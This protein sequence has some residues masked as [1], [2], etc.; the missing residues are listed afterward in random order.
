VD[1][2]L[3]SRLLALGSLPA[4]ALA[5]IAGGVG[6]PI[7]EEIVLLAAGALSH[8]GVTDPWITLPTCALAILV[9]DSVLYAL[10]RRLGPRL[11]ERGPFRH[12]ATPRRLERID[13]LFER[14]GDLLIFAARHMSL[15]RTLVF[16]VAATRG[17]AYRRFALL[18]ALGLIISAPLAFG[19]GY[20]FSAH[21]A[22]VEQKV[23]RAEHWAL[24]IAAAALVIAALV[25]QIRRF[26]RDRDE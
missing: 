6:A 24:A 12:L 1:H 23:A 14:R 18:D 22:M 26:L 17:V 21:V 19:L 11:L 5:L 20:F 13:R 8:R 3:L 2:D 15:L 10:A 16:V 4:L 25:F 9:G 7:P